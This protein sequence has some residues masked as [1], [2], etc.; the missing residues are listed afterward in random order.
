MPMTTELCELLAEL[1]KRAPLGLK[2]HAANPAAPVF[3]TARGKPHTY[4]S[5]RHRVLEVRERLLKVKD[6]PERKARPFTFKNLRDATVCNL[7]ALNKPTATAA[8]IVGH[9]HLA[10]TEKYLGLL[11]DQQREAIEA[12]S[13]VRFSERALAAKGGS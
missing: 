13:A 4:T 6:F 3:L 8:K 9:R 7:L 11:V 5:V 10:T 12:Y 1:R 2:T